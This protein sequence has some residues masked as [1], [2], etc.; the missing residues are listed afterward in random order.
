MRGWD[1]V[2]MKVR[3]GLEGEQK[4]QAMF[5]CNAAPQGEGVVSVGDYVYVRKTVV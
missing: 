1:L 3:S 2:L 4:G 5:G